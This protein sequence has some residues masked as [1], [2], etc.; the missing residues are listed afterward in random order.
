MSSEPPLNFNSGWDN[1]SAHWMFESP[2]L[3]HYP[4]S[5]PPGWGYALLVV[6]V[7]WAVV[8]V[9]MYPLCLWFAALKQRRSD[10]WLS[11]L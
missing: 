6:Y 7:A 2:D 3:A 1:P 8:V 11:Y 10:A 9:A 5:A 4:F